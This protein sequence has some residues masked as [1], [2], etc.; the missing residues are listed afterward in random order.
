MF[1][2]LTLNWEEIEEELLDFLNILNRPGYEFTRDFILKTSLTL[3]ETGAK[4]DVLKFRKEKNINNLRSEW[5]NIKSAISDI[6]DF[7]QNNTF[8]K[9]HKALPS[10]LALIPLIYY[11]YKF[12]DNWEAKKEEDL[13][14][15]L[16]RVMLAGAFSGSSDTILDA[17]IRNIKEKKDFDIDS[18]N[19][20][21]IK[22][23]RRVHITSETVLESRYGQKKIYLIFFML[24]KTRM[25]SFM[26]ASE[27]NLPTLDHI[28]PQSLLKSIKVKNP[29]TNRMITK[30]SKSE[31]DQIA[32][33]MVLSH[34]ENCA[35]KRDTP[36]DI[37]F[38][39][40]EEEYLR[41]HLIPHKEL[42]EKEKFE[43]FIKERKKLIIEE[44]KSSKLILIKED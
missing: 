21:I 22:Q 27:G 15:W 6:R 28:F 32:N 39:D 42:L 26:P 3:I 33:L 17:I 37:W 10:Y 38:T 16:T 20:I 44:L 35:G 24:Y 19:S 40:K 4:Y 1:S 9:N 5:G 41:L 29:K 7:I 11:K 14:F 34:G 12:P 31:R 23:G 25:P 18:I 30:Y 36:P 13:G 8:M 43:E 2:L